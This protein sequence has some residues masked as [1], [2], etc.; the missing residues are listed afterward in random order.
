MFSKKHSNAN[1]YM[2][3]VRDIPPVA[4]TI[5]WNRQIERQLDVYLSRVEDVLGK[6]WLHHV[7][8]AK[9]KVFCCLYFLL[10]IYRLQQICFAKDFLRARFLNNG[11][12]MLKPSAILKW[13]DVCLP[14]MMN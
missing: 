13:K 7:E 10:I 12:L 14:L 11:S 9:L 1:V 8:G 4:G 6:K 3:E 5:L 2:S